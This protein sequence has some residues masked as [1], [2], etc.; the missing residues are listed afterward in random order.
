M[1]FRGVSSQGWDMYDMQREHGRV[2]YRIA[3][4]TDGKIYG[5][6]VLLS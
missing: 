4:G 2:H 6:L 3:F 1:E 5:A